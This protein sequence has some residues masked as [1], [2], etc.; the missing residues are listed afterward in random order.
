M[1]VP[2][3]TPVTVLPATVQTPELRLLNATNIPEDAV[4]LTIPVPPTTRLFGALPNVID[5]LSRAGGGGATPHVEQR[6]VGLTV[7]SWQ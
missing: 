1:Q 5:W 2:A 7:P 4:A 6:Q 3:A